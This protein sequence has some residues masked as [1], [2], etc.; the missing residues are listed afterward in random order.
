MPQPHK[1]YIKQGSFPVCVIHW[2]EHLPPRCILYQIHSTALMTASVDFAVSPRVKLSFISDNAHVQHISI[3][4]SKQN[5]QE[6]GWATTEATIPK[7]SS[8]GQWR[9]RHLSVD[10]VADDQYHQP[11]PGTGTGWQQIRSFSG[12]MWLS[13]KSLP[14]TLKYPFVQGTW[15]F[16]TMNRGQHKKKPLARQASPSFF[17]AGLQVSRNNWTELEDW[18]L[19]CCFSKDLSSM[20]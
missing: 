19:A 18:P 11:H 14:S 1:R 2:G 6:R 4:Q 16:A 13:F 12:A 5:V 20:A 9:V 17:L 15:T 3:S 8:E 10:T 7:S